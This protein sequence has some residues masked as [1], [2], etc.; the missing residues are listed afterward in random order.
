VHLIS[1]EPVDFVAAFYLDTINVPYFRSTLMFSTL[2]NTDFFIMA[3]KLVQYGVIR[4][5]M[6]I[7]NVCSKPVIIAILA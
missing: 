4:Y 7:F 3:G 6:Q 1:C 2:N 5:D